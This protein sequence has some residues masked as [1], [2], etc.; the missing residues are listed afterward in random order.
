MTVKACPTA[1]IC[2]QRFDILD[3]AIDEIGLIIS[4]VSPASA[5]IAVYGEVL[6]KEPDEFRFLNLTSV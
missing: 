5:V 1:R 3:L 2:D 4:A 6:R